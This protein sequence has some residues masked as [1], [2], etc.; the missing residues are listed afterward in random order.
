MNKTLIEKIR[1]ISIL[2][3]AL[4]ALIQPFGASALPLSTY[5]G[6]SA[7]SE[8][9]WYKISVTESGL[10]LISN[11]SLRSMGFSD[12]S[13]VNVYG[14]GAERQP[15]HFRSYVDDLPLTPA[16]HTD[17]GIVFEAVGP[18]SFSDMRPVNN[19][20]TTKGYYFLSDR[21]TENT[22]P[23]IPGS[24]TAGEY[25]SMLVHE[26]EL[27]SPGKTGHELLGEDFLYTSKRTFNFNLD[28]NKGDKVAIQCSFAVKSTDYTNLT[29]KAN[30]EVVAT[31][32]LD[33]YT[34]DHGHY[35]ESIVD[36]TYSTQANKVAIEISFSGTGTTTLANLNYLTLKYTSD[37]IKPGTGTTYLTP[38]LEGPVANQN[39]HS[40][41]VPDM[42]IFTISNW[43]DQAKRLAQYRETN[44][45]L[46]VLV[47][48]Q[49]QV[50]NEFAS[51]SPDVNAF[52]KFLK[53]L[54]DRS[55]AIDSV[56]GPRLQ[57]ALFMGRGIHDNR[58][59]LSST[60]GLGYPLMPIWESDSGSS[61]TDSYTTDDIF[62]FLYDSTASSFSVQKYSIAVG[63]L[64]VVSTTSAKEAVDKIIEYETSM[65]TGEWRNKIMI[66]ADDKDSG[67]H[68]KQANNMHSNMQSRGGLGVFYHKLYID[69]FEQ[70][71]GKY[72]QAREVMFR[73]LDEGLAW[74][75]FI[76]HANTNSLT[77]ERVLTYTDIN[78]MYLRHYPVM[79]AACC[80]FLRF[81]APEISAAE[82]MWGL[83]SGGASAIISA[84]RP[85]YIP[86]NGKMSESLGNYM[87]LRDNDGR[88]LPLG[89]IVRRAKNDLNSESNKLRYVLIGDPSMRTLT[90]DNKVV[91]TKV[92]GVELGTD[93]PAELMARQ[94][95]TIEGYVADYKGDIIPDFSGVIS[96]TVY[97]AEYSVV[98]KGHTTPG[99]EDGIPV[100]FQQIGDRIFAGN[101]SIVNGRFTMNVA[102]PSSIAENYTPAAANL[103]A[104]SLNPSAHADA[105][106]LNRDFYVF[107]EDLTANDTLP[108]VI[109]KIYIN[110][111]D[112]TDGAFV[113]SSPMLIAEVADE[114]G[115]NISTAGLGHQM[116][117]L[118]DDKK[119]FTDVCNY[120]TP[121][122]SEPGAGVIAYPLPEIA[123]G[124]H[125]LRLRVYDTSDNSAASELSFVVSPDQAPTLYDVY[126]DTNPASTQANFYLSHDRPDA[127]IEVTI[128][129]FNL[130]GK[131]IWSS[132]TSGRSDMYLSFPITWNLTDQAGSRVSRGVYLYQASVKAD[133]IESATKTKR[134]AVTG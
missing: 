48:D 107:G 57:Y 88:H 69:E 55:E 44:N 15:D 3:V 78:T 42:V 99:E 102:M 31:K 30:G 6:S 80:D 54:W 76:G 132:T 52:R 118:L 4:F 21:P 63:R 35:R 14:Y 83:K 12:P 19:P 17:R 33:R 38:A 82:I 111:P 51:G 79:Y 89:E 68:M 40:A 1:Y 65:P 34:A 100:T 85:T 7:L 77:H 18:L 105:C 130:L 8:G 108:P 121:S 95:T 59:L 37:A 47:V 2:T 16:M 41:D 49:Q 101:D 9:R 133:G 74:W 10:H 50:F 126:T 127:N 117:I 94:S 45:G 81:D 64:P 122:V 91:L 113:N 128:T 86:S 70:E 131:P 72:P 125:K 58:Q 84:V 103:Y 25:K 26:Q 129:V 20:F 43:A 92:G 46:K 112:F 56:G 67:V 75:V 29:L 104:K 53:M 116:S 27:M 71:A 23:E 115:L 5:A 120:F 110:H 90:P 32:R 62:A 134:I 11:A 73:K 60:R 93:Q 109:R 39:L 97:D 24:L 61:D 87:F 119:S 98:T 124:A 66:L 36:A 96:A 123:K 106:G 22:P 28:G 13:K 114:T